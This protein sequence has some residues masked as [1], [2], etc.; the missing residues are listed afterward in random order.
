MT[1]FRNASLKFAAILVVWGTFSVTALAYSVYIVTRLSLSFFQ[2]NGMINNP[3]ILEAV[4]YQVFSIEPVFFF[5]L[6]LGFFGVGVT[7][8]LFSNSQYNYFK[9]LSEA[10]AEYSVSGKI[11]SMKNLGPFSSYFSNFV[12]IISLRLEKK[13]DE[14]IS[15]RLHDIDKLWPL[16]PKMSWFDQ[17]QFASIAVLISGFFSMVSLIFF[18]KVT[19]RLIELSGMLIRYKVATGPSFFNAQIEIVNLVMWTIFILM[20]LAFA[21]TGY[22]FG[23]NVSQASYAVLRDLRKFMYG[24][25]NQRIFLRSDDPA[26]VLT[27]GMNDSLQRIAERIRS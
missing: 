24:D 17:L 25:L 8:F 27:P 9:R 2:A 7:S 3:E 21:G 4:Y 26:R 18:W 22:I 15:T 12:S 11:P 14:V 19:D 1:S 13:G 23:K 10:L 6:V 20:T 16:T 5:M